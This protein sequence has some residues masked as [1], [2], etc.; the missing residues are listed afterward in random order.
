MKHLRSEEEVRYVSNVVD[1]LRHFTRLRRWC[2]GTNATIIPRYL[3]VLGI[4]E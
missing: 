1:E 4:F 3:L 2:E